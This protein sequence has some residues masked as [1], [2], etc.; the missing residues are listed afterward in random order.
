VT[1]AETVSAPRWISYV[2]LENLT[3]AVRNPKLHELERI[4]AS[5]ERHG[6]VETPVADERTQRIISGA[7]RR[8]ALIEMQTRGAR[9]PTGL[10]MDHDAGWLVPV[11][12]GWRSRSDAEAETLI[13]NLNRLT[14]AGGW[15]GRILAA[16]L[17]DL[18]TGDAELFDALHYADDEMENLLRNV[19]PESLGPTDPDNPDPALRMDSGDGNIPGLNDEPQGVTCP[20][21]GL[22]FTPG[23]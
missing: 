2:P 1:D 13:I 6:F 17:E 23:R 18:A 10:M 9:M 5:I 3:V 8:E 21:C 12:R 14:E 7:G 11:L 15:D 19:N 4:I 20:S 22:H 16:M